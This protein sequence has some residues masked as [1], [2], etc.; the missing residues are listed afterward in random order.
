MKI[1]A[2]PNP[3]HIQKLTDKY[4]VRIAQHITK[5][6]TG[7]YKIRLTTNKKQHYYGTWPKHEVQQILDFLKTQPQPE[8]YTPTNLKLRGSKYKEKIR[9]IIKETSP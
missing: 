1:I 6:H 2:Q 4:N 9:Q 7:Q 3:E 8:K 5:T